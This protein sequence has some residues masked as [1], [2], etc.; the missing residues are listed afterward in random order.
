MTPPSIGRRGS[1]PGLWLL[2]SLAEGPKHGHAMMLDIEQLS[3]HRLGPGTLYGALQRLEQDGLVE[4][5]P[6][7]QR[8]TPYRLTEAG[9]SHLRTRLAELQTIVRLG[10][11][12]VG[13]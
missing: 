8:R 6:D 2:V 9:R 1:D 12:R 4:A 3:G 5:L 13:S 7:D 11:A 10:T